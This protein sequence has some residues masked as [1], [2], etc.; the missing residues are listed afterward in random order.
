MICKQGRTVFD[1]QTFATTG[2][3]RVNESRHWDDESVC[4]GSTCESPRPISDTERLDWLDAHEPTLGIL[5]ESWHVF[6]P[7]RG[8]PAIGGTVR[9][10]IDA[11][12]RKERKP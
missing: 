3:S 5:G 1:S 9:E 11:A 4:F 8:G 7:F 6:L 2:V 10:A 12:I